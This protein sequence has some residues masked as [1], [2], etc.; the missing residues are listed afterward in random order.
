MSLATR[1][2]SVGG[3][4]LVVFATSFSDLGLS[5][6]NLILGASC[7]QVSS[8]YP[9]IAGK[10]L[11]FGFKIIYADLVRLQLR[12]RAC[13]SVVP[14]TRVRAAFARNPRIRRGVHAVLVVELTACA[15]RCRYRLLVFY[16]EVVVFPLQEM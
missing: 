14:L 2:W 16:F 9:Q 11:T 13:N 12:A 4:F 6:R 10:E 1:A 3:V 8:A 15:G 7:P 5:H